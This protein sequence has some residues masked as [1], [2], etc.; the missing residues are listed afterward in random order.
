MIEQAEL[1]LTFSASKAR[2]DPARL[3]QFLRGRE[4]TTAREIFNRSGIT[5]RQARS[6]AAASEG[7]I[8][9]GQRGYKLTQEATIEEVQHAAGWLRSQANE[10]THR[11]LEIDRVYHRKTRF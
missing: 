4:W 1:P 2:P 7:Q 3:M 6:L 5:D 10:M 11:A 8:I 9:S